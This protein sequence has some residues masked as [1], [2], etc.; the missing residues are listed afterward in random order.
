MIELDRLS[1]CENFAYVV[2][3]NVDHLVMLHEGQDEGVR[4]RF[5]EAYKAAALR[6][7]DS[8]I[9]KLLA[10]LRGIDLEVVTG[11]DVTAH[12]FASGHFNGKKVA[13]VGGD[14]ATLLELRT[15]FPDID[16]VQHIPPMGVLKDQHAADEIEAFVAANPCHYVLLAIGAPQSEIVA[17]QCLQ[18]GRSKGVG[19]CVGASI[20]FVL[21]RKARAPLWLQRANLEW[22]FRLMSEPKRLWR[23]YLMTGPQ[24]FKL[25]FRFEKSE[26]L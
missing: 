1:Q 23:R 5:N 7:C 16:L 19:L 10:K 24:I 3:P 22:A 9:L 26:P 21:G 25:A 15:R 11:S 13:I 8:R 4:Q 12:L 2:T 20:D 18:A 14:E 17:A 6:I